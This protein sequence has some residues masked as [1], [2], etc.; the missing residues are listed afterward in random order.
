M[1]PYSTEFL[2]TLDP[3]VAAL[4]LEQER[5][6]TESQ[7]PQEFGHQT[8]LS[9]ERHNISGDESY[10]TAGPDNTQ[11]VVDGAPDDTPSL[12]ELKVQAVVAC[13]P[14]HLQ[15]TYFLVYFERLTLREAGERLGIAHTSVKARLRTVEKAVERAVG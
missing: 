12:S 15:E 10:D 2:A 1:S 9:F 4:A 6:D 14:E 11:V 3:E 5:D 8:V 7:R 13:L